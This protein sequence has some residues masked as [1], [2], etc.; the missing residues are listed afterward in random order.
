MASG[1]DRKW[2]LFCFVCCFE[3]DCLVLTTLVNS[4]KR[5][6]PVF[7]CFVDVFAEE[8]EMGFLCQ[9]GDFCRTIFNNKLAGKY[10]PFHNGNCLT[11]VC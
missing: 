6:R 11:S 8:I 4:S 2:V 10:E 7:A 3:F 9:D 5:W 1:K